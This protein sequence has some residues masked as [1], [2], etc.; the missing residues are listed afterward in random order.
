MHG[1]H[2]VVLSNSDISVLGPSLQFQCSNAARLGRPDGAGRCSALLLKRHA[3]LIGA[4]YIV[5][6]AVR[7]VCDDGCIDNPSFGSASIR[8]RVNTPPSPGHCSVMPRT[9]RPLVTLFRLSCRQWADTHQPL[10]YHFALRLSD[11]SLLPL[12]SS[13]SAAD[14]ALTLPSGHAEVMLT[15]EDGLG[16]EHQVLAQNLSA[17]N[18]LPPTF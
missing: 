1:P 11:G 4:I 3:L 6:V 8:L 10:R 18:L 17:P 13:T 12:L 16:A 7:R 5:E 15:V 14:V 9:G 2:D